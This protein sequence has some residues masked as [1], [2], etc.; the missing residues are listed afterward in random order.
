MGSATERLVR[1]VQDLDLDAI[2]NGVRRTARTAILDGLACAVGGCGTRVG[3]AVRELVL[4]E[5]G[6][7]AATLWGTRVRSSPARTAL[8]NGASAH[9]LDF[10]DVLWPMNGHPTAPVLP[11]VLAVAESRGS[12]GS[13]VLA[14]YVAGVEAAAALGYA[15][16]RPHYERGWHPTA[17]LGALGA[18]LAAGKLG[19]LSREELSRA[20]GIA[21]SQLAGSRM[22]FGT[23]TKPLHAGLA[24]QVGVLATDLAARGLTATTDPLGEELGLAGLYHGPSSLE[25]PSLGDPFALESPGLDLKPYPSCR[26]THRTIDAVLDIRSTRG[27]ESVKTIECWIDLLALKILI[28]PQPADGLEAKFSLPYCAAIAWIDGWPAVESFS[29]ARATR[30]DVQELLNRVRVSEASAPEEE[31][32]ITFSSGA[33]ERRRILH[34]RGS[35]DRPMERDDHVRKVRSLCVPVLG[36]E[37]TDELVSVVSQ[38]ETLDDMGELAK[39]LTP[40]EPAGTHVP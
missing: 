16:G 27:R 14:A 10:D 32:E 20:L 28:H 39:L 11:A 36:A 9:A 8:A 22:N 12:S 34:P 6:R 13:E 5:G 30:A 37:R 18:T 1:F 23:D 7:P 15:M 35:P 3:A 21:C 2:P 31:V 26:F 19:E 25:L 38:L 33:R 4:S 17:T 29:D 40:E 24:A